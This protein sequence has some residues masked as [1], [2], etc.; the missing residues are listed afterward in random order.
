M[1]HLKPAFG[2]PW[3]S[4]KTVAQLW[5]E[6]G[7]RLAWLRSIAQPTRPAQAEMEML[8]KVKGVNWEEGVWRARYSLDGRRKDLGAFKSKA[9]AIK[10]RK[11]AEAQYG[12]EQP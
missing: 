3:K 12:P 1:S 6:D 11:A 8:D 2:F 10:A 7:T 9:A 4:H 5:R